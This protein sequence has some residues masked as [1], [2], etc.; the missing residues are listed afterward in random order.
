MYVK[1]YHELKKQQFSSSFSFLLF[2][3]LLVL[4]LVFIFVLEQI[5]GWTARN[6]LSWGE[7][8][9]STLLWESTSV[10]LI[11][12]VPVAADWVGG[13]WVEAL[14]WWSVFQLKL[15][16]IKVMWSLRVVITWPGISGDLSWVASGN[17]WPG[18][19]SLDSDTIKVEE[20]N[21]RGINL[22]L[23]SVKMVWSLGV[24]IAW[25]GVGGDLSWVASSNRWPF[26]SSLNSGAIDVEENDIGGIELNLGAIEMVWSLGV[27]IA[28]PGV[29][30][31][32][33]WVA[34]G[35]R[36]PFEL[37]SVGRGEESR[38]NK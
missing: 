22:N 17:G 13:L 8:R 1:S 14:D 32:L 25:P 31:D 30:G 34:S 9:D 11:D 2:L 10:G 6:F 7:A 5:N 20:S 24:V 23:S 19:S 35:N 16:T 3:W 26:L 12:I 4:F 18:L 21:I 15:G 38:N 28:W 29:S 27:V 37:N 33:S 36:W